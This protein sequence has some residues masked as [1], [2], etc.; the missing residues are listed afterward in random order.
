MSFEMKYP[1][2]KS[3]HNERYPEGY[4]NDYNERYSEGYHERYSPEYNNPD[5]QIQYTLAKQF[6]F[7]EKLSEKV[8]DSIW[9]YTCFDYVE[10]N[11]MLRENERLF[12]KHQTIINNIDYAFQNS[13][14]LE[15]EIIVYRKLRVFDVNKM[16]SVISATY[17]KNFVSKFRA[18]CCILVITLPVGSSVLPIESISNVP[19]EKEILLNRK[20]MYFITK[21][22]DETYA[23]KEEEKTGETHTVYTYHI[24]YIPESSV[25]V[26]N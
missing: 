4:S 10:L 18:D 2:R 13:P 25:L 1:E 11:R 7:V 24:S 21:E 8:K 19:E 14:K 5:R 12:P 23:N 26:Q 9:Q 20:G 17:D 22:G 15:K 6:E 16:T 3:N